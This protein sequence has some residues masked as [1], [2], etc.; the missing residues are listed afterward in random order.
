MKL[1][2]DIKRKYTIF[3]FDTGYFFDNIASREINSK[4]LNNISSF[5]LSRSLFAKLIILY[6]MMYRMFVLY[7]AVPYARTRNVNV[8]NA[9]LLFR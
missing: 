1:Q 2:W 8:T 3:Y 6:F 9:P 4:D 7:C 5:R